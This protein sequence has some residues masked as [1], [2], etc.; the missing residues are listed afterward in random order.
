MQARFAFSSAE[1]SGIIDSLNEIPGDGY[2][3][4]ALKRWPLDSSKAFGVKLSERRESRIGFDPA[5]IDRSY[6]VEMVTL[7]EPGWQNCAS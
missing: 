5:V 7:A 3:E 2:A 4:F 1:R 6:R